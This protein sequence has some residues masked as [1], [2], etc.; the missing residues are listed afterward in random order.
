MSIAVK[1]NIIIRYTKAIISS[2]FIPM[3]LEVSL[4]IQPCIHISYKSLN[5]HQAD[6][7]GGV[8]NSESYI[9]LSITL[10]ANDKLR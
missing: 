9:R 3:Y 8:Q 5:M 6:N 4:I 1:E 2:G 7:S 10:C